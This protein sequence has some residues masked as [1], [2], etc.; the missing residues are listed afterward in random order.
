[1]QH[2]TTSPRTNAP[3][4]RRGEVHLGALGLTVLG[5]TLLTLFASDLVAFASSLPEMCM[6][7]VDSLTQRE[8]WYRL[9]GESGRYS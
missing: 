8:T 2:P 6:D 3:R 1:M 5:A 4:P 9:I 7:F